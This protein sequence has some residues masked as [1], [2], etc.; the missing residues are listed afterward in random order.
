MYRSMIAA[1]LVIPAVPSSPAVF[2]LCPS[3]SSIPHLNLLKAPESEVDYSRSVIWQTKLSLD[4]V[5]LDKRPIGSDADHDHA[6][7]IELMNLQGTR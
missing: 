6:F 2:R 4:N 5:E 7:D 3:F 1:L